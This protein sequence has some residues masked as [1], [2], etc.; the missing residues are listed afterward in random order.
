[1]EKGR[2][3]EWC[4]LLLPTSLSTCIAFLNPTFQNVLPRCYEPKK[5]GRCAAFLPRFFYNQT[6]G[7][8]EY[9]IY[10]GCQGNGN[11]FSTLEEC[12]EICRKGGGARCYEPKK[13]GRCAA[14]LPRFF[15]NQTTG[16]CEYFI[17]RGCQGNGNR[18]STLEECQ[19][20][21]Q[22]GGEENP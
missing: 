21:C 17:Y 1:M 12:Q 19:E 4:W 8:C 5:V 18:F 22:R 13:V 14:Y 15:Y 7:H 20:I 11:R 16:Y 6:M 9:F 3:E 10:R 2:R